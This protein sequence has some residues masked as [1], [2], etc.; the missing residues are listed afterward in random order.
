ML[1]LLTTPDTRGKLAP[2]I[3]VLFIPDELVQ[4]GSSVAYRLRD[5]FVTPALSSLPER[6]NRVMA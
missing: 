1:D 6:R 3:P 4:A 5:D 2:Q